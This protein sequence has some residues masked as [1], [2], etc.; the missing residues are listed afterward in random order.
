MSASNPVELAAEI[1]SAF[2]S[3]NPVPK[4]ELPLLIQTVHSAVERLANGPESAPPR[5]EGNAPA[6]AI[7]RSITPDFLI[8]LEDGKDSR[9]CAVTWPGTA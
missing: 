2:V 9:L 5:V 1:V 4:G 3:Y 7:R 6:A 8:C